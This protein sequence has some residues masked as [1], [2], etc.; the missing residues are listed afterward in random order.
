MI[1]YIKE[2]KF[3][4]ILEENS[5]NKLLFYGNSLDCSELDSF[6]W[7]LNNK[8][9]KNQIEGA[10]CLDG[11]PIWDLISP[12]PSTSPSTAP[13]T[14][15]LP[16]LS[17]TTSTTERPIGTDE[18]DGDGDSGFKCQ[19]LALILIIPVLSFML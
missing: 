16:T 17:T 13:P 11:T 10:D 18:P 19:P 3:K 15:A 5:K 4:A 1:E 7:L 9:Y 12:T 2:E 8:N 6:K 14:T